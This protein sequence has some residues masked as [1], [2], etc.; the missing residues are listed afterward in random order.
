M[1]I[2]IASV[3]LPIFGVLDGAIVKKKSVI[4]L[5]EE[6][7][8]WH[9]DPDEEGLLLPFKPLHSPNTRASLPPYFMT[10]LRPLPH[11]APS[12]LHLLH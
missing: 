6:S 4:I 12:R 10:A 11:N 3:V 7:T 9:D 2:P 8:G 1:Q 5:E